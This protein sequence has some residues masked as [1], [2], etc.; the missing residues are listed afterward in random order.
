MLNGLAVASIWAAFIIVSRGSPLPPEPPETANGNSDFRL[1]I[2]V[3]PLMSYKMIREIG[4][5]WKILELLD[6]DKLV[7]HNDH[8]AISGAEIIYTFQPK[9]T[10]GF[11]KTGVRGEFV[12]TSDLTF[13]EQCLKYHVSWMRNGTIEGTKCL[14]T[15]PNWMREKESV[16]GS[17]RLNEIFIPGTHDSGAYFKSEKPKMETLVDKYII[18]QDEDVLSQ[19][20]YGV[21]YLDI[22]VGR[23]PG[24]QDLWWI[25][26]GFFSVH[27]LRLVIDDVKTFLDNTQEIVIFD[28]QEFPVGFA[29]MGNKY[30]EE[31]IAFLEKSF[32]G[33]YLPK[34]NTKGWGMTLDDI[35]A[36]GKRLIIGYDHSKVWPSHESTWSPVTHRWPDVK[37]LDDLYSKVHKYEEGID[38]VDNY[39]QTDRPPSSVMAQ[40]TP[41]AM[42]A[43]LDSLGGLRKMAELVNMNV[44]DSYNE[45][46]KC[47][48]NIVSMDYIKSSGIIETALNMN[49]RNFT[50]C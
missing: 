32:A 49:N 43:L 40:L 38:P 17:K 4:I 27:P 31:L 39:E 13:R 25:N 22:R 46:W 11:H 33:Y 23:Y 5:Y 6:G 35:W 47:T 9:D 45:L 18:T 1:G 44:T 41:D 29:G 37:T 21:R 8:P 36:T 24:I 42:D 15:H 20:I 30:H 19:L 26:H 12:A 16:L 10:R 34:N 48:A 2:V 50:G 28:V 7:L 14:G 3:S